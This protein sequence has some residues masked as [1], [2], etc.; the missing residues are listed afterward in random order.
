MGLRSLVGLVAG[1]GELL[2]VKLPLRILRALRNHQR[3]SGFHERRRAA[4]DFFPVVICLGRQVA[5]ASGVDYR[6]IFA[7]DDLGRGRQHMLKPFLAAI[8]T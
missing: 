4:D 6:P 1:I 5:L 8:Q 7:P 2:D 3:V